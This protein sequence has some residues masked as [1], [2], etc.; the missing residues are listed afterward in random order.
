MED[1]T[2][3][4]QQVNNLLN[5]IEKYR[6]D[7][8]RLKTVQSSLERSEQNISNDKRELQSHLKKVIE[9]KDYMEHQIKKLANKNTVLV[10]RLR[11]SQL[12]QKEM[13]F[14][15]QLGVATTCDIAQQKACT[16]LL[17]YQ[18]TLVSYPLT[19]FTGIT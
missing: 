15:A 19:S 9:E 4:Q 13:D 10:E 8:E 2:K 11:Q 5:D 16:L 7:V 6:E 17:E 18:K 14:Q 3:L 1:K 12:K